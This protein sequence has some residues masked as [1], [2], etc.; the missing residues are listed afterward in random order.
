MLFPT[1][2]AAAALVGVRSRLSPLWL[3]VGATIP[4]AVDKPL[5][6]VG[7]V[8]LFHTV[9]HSALVLALALPLI[10]VGPRSRAVVAGWASHLFLDAFHIVLNGRAEDTLFLGWPVTSPPTPLGIPPGE[11]F[12]YYLWSPSFFVELGIWAALA[13]VLAQWLR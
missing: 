6:A 5:A 13:V 11:F 10:R 4:D 12:L 7:V 2:L 9:G 1:H 3:V 8:E